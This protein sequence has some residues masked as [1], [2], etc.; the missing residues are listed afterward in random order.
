[1]PSP[2][3]YS[4]VTFRRGEDP[5]YPRMIIFAAPEPSRPGLAQCDVW[6][7][8]RL[9]INLYNQFL[10]TD[11][12]PVYGDVFFHLGFPEVVIDMSGLRRDTDSGGRMLSAGQSE[13]LMELF[14][15]MVPTVLEIAREQIP[16]LIE[17]QRIDAVTVVERRGRE[18]QNALIELARIDSAG[19]LPLALQEVS[20]G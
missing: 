3:D 14:R 15:R 6:S 5:N 9:R 8:D 19:G 13:A 10:S 20:H 17:R 2:Y 11:R 16:A 4:T 1:M 7:T 12:R 18:L